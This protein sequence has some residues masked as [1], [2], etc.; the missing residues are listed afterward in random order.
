MLLTLAA[1]IEARALLAESIELLREH[2]RWSYADLGAKLGKSRQWAYKLVH[3]D[4]GGTPLNNIDALTKVF[5]EATGY[6]FLPSDLFQPDTL[7]TKLGEGVTNPDR[8]SSKIPETL[9]T[10]DL[11]NAKQ[12]GDQVNHLERTIARQT[13]LWFDCYTALHR[14]FGGSPAHVRSPAA[15]EAKRTP[16][17]GRKPR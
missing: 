11:P 12:L 2:L 10:R 6:V 17:S 4:D 7:L 1:P 5:S 15:T 3:D 16:R 14:H 13:A 8:L 9:N